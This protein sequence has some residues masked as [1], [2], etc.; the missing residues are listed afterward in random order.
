MYLHRHV[1]EQHIGRK[2]SSTEQVNHINGDRHDNRIEN[3]EI[4]N[5]LEH[6]ALSSRQRLVKIVSLTAE[7]STK[8]PLLI[9][10]DCDRCPSFP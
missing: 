2:L 7:R 9:E 6:G 5:A 1:M 4:L 3:L 8:R 10:P